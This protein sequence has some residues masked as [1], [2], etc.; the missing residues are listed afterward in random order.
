MR[1]LIYS[2]LVS[3][4]IGILFSCTDSKQNKEEEKVAL[5]K[6]NWSDTMALAKAIDVFYTDSVLNQGKIALDVRDAVIRSKVPYHYLQLHKIYRPKFKLASATMGYMPVL[7]ISGVDSVIVD[8]QITW[9]QISPK[10][11]LGKFMVTDKFAQLVNN[12]PRYEWIQ[13]EEYWIRKNVETPLNE[14]KK[15]NEKGNEIEKGNIIK[16]EKVMDINQIKKKE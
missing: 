2:L 11:S 1:Y 15:G 7:M 9:Q 13:E 5:M 6:A 10:D 3:V 14:I 12:Q 4:F 16:K 8:F